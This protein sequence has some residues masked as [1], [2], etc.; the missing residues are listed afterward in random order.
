V[1]LDWVAA[2]ES[3]RVAQGEVDGME[4]VEGKAAH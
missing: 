3:C 4:K 2:V 1:V